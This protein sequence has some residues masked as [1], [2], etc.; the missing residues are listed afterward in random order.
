MR[1]GEVLVDRA[2]AFD[3][4]GHGIQTHAVDPEIEPESHDINDGP[5]YSRI[6]EIEVGLVGVKPMPVISLRH[7]VPRPVGFLGVDKDDAGFRKFLVRVAPHI[8]IAQR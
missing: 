8:E 2:L 1:F 4:I 7:R 5:Q 6:V 3:Q